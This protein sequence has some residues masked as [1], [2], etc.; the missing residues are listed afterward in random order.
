MLCADPSGLLTS[1][2][3]CMVTAQQG[4]DISVLPRLQVME[5][6]VI[7]I[8]NFAEWEYLANSNFQKRFRY[9]ELSSAISLACL[10]VVKFKGNKKFTKE[11]W[12]LSEFNMNVQLRM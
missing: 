9:L 3:K 4:S 1:C 7:T 5:L 2:K 8:L 6:C 12:D 10:D 11:C